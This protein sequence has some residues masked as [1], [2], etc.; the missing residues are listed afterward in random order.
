MLTRRHALAL[1]TGSLVL[2]QA[3]ALNP[4]PP[5]ATLRIEVD[6][7]D[8]DR[9]IL[10]VQERLRV[11]P[12]R[13][14]L[15]MVKWIAGYHSPDGDPVRIA[16]LTIHT[17]QGQRLAWRRPATDIWAFEV[18]VPEGVSEL[19]LAYQQL[20]YQSADHGRITMTPAL[21]HVQW[22][23]VTL[24]PSEPALTEMRVEAAVKL[25]R[26]WG[27]GSALR[28]PGGQLANA[29]AEGW[30]RFEP[31]SLYTL[32]DSPVFAGRHQRRIELDGGA[33]PVA[34]H[35]FGDTP[36][37]LAVSPAQIQAHRQLVQQADRLFGARH[38]R[39]YDLLLALSKAFGGIGLEHHEC[40]ENG[41]KPGY[42]KDWD[43]GIRSRGLLPHEYL[44]SWNAK[45]RR[46]ADLFSGRFEDPM[47]GTLLWVYEGQTN[48]WGDMLTPRAG[49]ATPAQARDRLARD[50]AELD[51]R[52]GRLWRP[53]QDTTH[54]PVLTVRTE[55]EW[56]SWQ[57]NGDYYAEGTLLWLDVDTLIRVLSHGKRSLEDFARAFFGIHDGRVETL[58]Y[59]LD[60]V[61]ATLTQVWPHDWASFLRQRLE[62]VGEGAPLEGLHRSGW[63][64]AWADSPSDEALFDAAEDPDK[65]V[66]DF[67][68]SI[69]LATG[70]DG[71]I[72]EVMWDSPAFQAGIPPYATLVAVNGLAFD[73]DR[74]DAALRSNRQGEQP[75]ELLIRDGE[76][77]RPV[78]I[79]Y[80]GGPRHP[81]LEPI[82]GAKDWLSLIMSPKTA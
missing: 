1:A 12:G 73:P 45:F 4:V 2:P 27:A 30:W 19:R 38:F 71:R 59:T 40:S 32:I 17:A 75:L 61:I 52:R 65:E 63:R 26:G 44:H 57:R 82:P 56:P 46:P 10:Q 79:D 81:R 24:Y 7:T 69:G 80:R 21:L 31:C 64:L 74:L 8:L 78:R 54:D 50:F 35:V 13:L 41:L 51:A 18:E 68:Y 22:D 47:Q 36:D 37:E 29:D 62:R 28:G 66:H 39:H 53:L 16:G 43:K 20:T 34:L 15:R 25:P 58:T 48:Y 76:R 33:R 9:R 6:A 3:R 11:A 72:T 23:T 60:D 67:R 49:L 77:Y 55:K 42:F 5:P 70:K 14:T